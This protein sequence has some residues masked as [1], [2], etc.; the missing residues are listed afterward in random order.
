MGGNLPQQVLYTHPPGARA[1]AARGLGRHGAT[2]CILIQLELERSSVP[3]PRYREGPTGESLAELAGFQSAGPNL[4][5]KPPIR[6]MLG[7]PLPSHRRGLGLLWHPSGPPPLPSPYRSSSP[8]IA[9]MVSLKTPTAVSP[10][11][12]SSNVHR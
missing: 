5:T 4:A 2:C 1:L 3:G 9:S 6:S 7:L 11:R 12:L 8:T 10:R